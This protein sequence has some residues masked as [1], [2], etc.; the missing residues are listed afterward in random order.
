MV[1]ESE[2][3]KFL[4]GATTGD[5]SFRVVSQEVDVKGRIV[6]SSNTGRMFGF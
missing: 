4:K 5:S 1:Q 2:G 3:V 6:F